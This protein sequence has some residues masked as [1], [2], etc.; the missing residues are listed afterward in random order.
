MKYCGPGA[1]R[2]A[3]A[4]RGVNQA[5]NLPRHTF[6]PRCDVKRSKQRTRRGNVA[7]WNIVY[8]AAR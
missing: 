2:D 5:R 7:Q 1:I 6:D 3:R 4:I 8:F